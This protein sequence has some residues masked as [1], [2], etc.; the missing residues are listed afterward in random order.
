[1]KELNRQ[2]PPELKVPERIRFEFPKVQHLS[3]GIPVYV[4]EA[5]VQ[6]VFR[7]ELVY[8]AG[9]KAD[10]RFLLGNLVP[11]LLKE[12]TKSFDGASLAKAFDKYGLN[13]K[14]KASPDIASI[15]VHGLTRNMPQA[16]PL[17]SDMVRNPAFP[18]K[19]VANFLNQREQ[20]MKQRLEQNSY[21][22][23]LKLLN[24][25]FGEKHPLGFAYEPEAFRTVKI[26]DLQDFHKKY[27]H[28]GN[29]TIFLSGRPSSEAVK[30]L[31]DH[32]GQQVYPGK[33]APGDKIWS[34]VSSED[35]KIHIERPDKVQAAI[36]IGMRS[37]A[38]EHP[39]FPEWSMVNMTLGGFFGSRLMKNIREEKGYTYGIYSSLG[40]YKS[41]SY[42]SIECECDKTYR[43]D[44]I[45]EIYHEINRLKTELVSEEELNIIRNYWLG[46][47][48][49]QVDGPF[50]RAN[51]LK[52]LVING[53][54]ENYLNRVLDTVSHIGP[55]R[56]RE[57]ARKYLD[58]D[59]MHE[60]VVG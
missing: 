59:S 39:D 5:G 24:N 43:E 53:L 44:V 31:E 9:R 58:T 35:R 41:G 6:E 40:A 16:L 29:C 12:G 28:A 23:G 26:S 22:A 27:Y 4:V 14:A 36:S 57:I 21:V 20:K 50:N 49:S 52:G 1:M 30:M 25:L 18:K 3:N 42:F 10:S 37:I 34:A 60:V 19:E 48:L 54:N 55:E 7:L 2:I 56:I 47:L 8:H 45:K 32:F 51:M 13:V 17:L 38:R 46:K 11:P 15:A 33:E